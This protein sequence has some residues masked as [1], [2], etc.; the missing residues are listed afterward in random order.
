MVVV[1]FG[2]TSVGAVPQIDRAARI[3][4][5]MRESKPVVILS[6]MGGVTDL[7]LQ[8]GEAAVSGQVQVR[9]DKLWEIRSRHDQAINE[10][11]KDR[12]VAVALQDT[13][14]L[15][16]EEIQKVFTG[17][18]LLRE[19]SARSR[20]LIGS[21][22]ERLIVPI[23]ARYLMQL[24]MEAEPV[25]AR[26]LIIT[27]EESEFL[28]VDFDETR[29]RC[30]KLA[31]MSKSNVVPVVTGFICSTPAGV[32]TTLGRGGSDYSASIIGACLKSDEIQIWT[33]VNGVMTADPRI[34]PDAR[35]LDRV[36]YKEAAEMSYF[37]AKVLHPKT[38]MPAVDENIP[39]RIK[40]TFAPEVPGTIIS[41]E[42][43]AHQYGVKTVTSITG[44][45]LVS[46]EGRGMIG[47]PGVAGRVFTTTA[48]NRISVL[49]FSQG[50]SE[51]HIS[52]VVNK[53]DGEN[54]VKALRREFEAEIERRRIDRV[55][56][57]SEIAIIA[58][59]GEG[60]KGVPGVAARA[61]GVL[62]TANIN[63]QMIAQG[64][65]ELNLSIVVRQKDAPR[66]VQLI[67]EAFE[68]NKA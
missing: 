19:M 27:S 18:S 43:P 38:I 32:T 8:A 42:S 62:G 52:I 4:L 44:M 10:L 13:E 66:A 53:Q 21:F 67:H 56:A 68:L 36:S 16:W 64:S 12:G 65:S 41:A 29:K 34:V 15:L 6:A 59:V 23:F 35:V 33:D 54:A 45:M 60:I 31:R 2:G 11:F 55:A 39:I 40:N 9:D 28:L 14:R 51:Q 1:K 3:I 63:I 50:S 61:F 30:Q 26:E 24:G 58:L 47:V 48:R 49:M 22:G 25:D 7:L 5:S 57:I 37:G 20:D 46:V 17:V